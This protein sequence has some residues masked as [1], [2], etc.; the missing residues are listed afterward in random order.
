VEVVTRALGLSYWALLVWD[1]R[2]SIAR[3]VK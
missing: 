1:L 2:V 3:T